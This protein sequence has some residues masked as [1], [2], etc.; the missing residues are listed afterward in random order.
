[1]PK[2]LVMCMNGRIQCSRVPVTK[3]GTVKP[4]KQTI[5]ISWEN[6]KISWDEKIFRKFPK[7]WPKR[8]CKTDSVPNK[9][10]RK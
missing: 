10:R 3:D 5:P 4:V 8:I 7:I 6:K 9:I 2:E 1:M